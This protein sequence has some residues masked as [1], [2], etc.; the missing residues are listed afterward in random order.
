[1]A[2]L[3]LAIRARIADTQRQLNG[4]AVSADKVEKEFNQVAGAAKNV[5]REGAKA[6]A[7]LGR[8]NA[9]GRNT[10]QI[11]FQAGQAVSDFAV[12]GI[13][14]AA[15]NL[16]FL[17]LQLGA[18]SPV[19]LGVTALSVAFL[20]FEDDITGFLSGTSAEIENLRGNVKSLADELIQVRDGA[21]V[22]FEGTVDE[23]EADAER[24][25]AV[26]ERLIAQRNAIQGR[27][28][29]QQFQN[30]GGVSVVA[31]LTQESKELEEQVEQINRV[32]AR[33]QA[34][35]ESINTT[36]ED[37]KLLQT[38]IA[39][40]EG[41]TLEKKEK[42][43]KAERE[44]LTLL[45]RAE[46]SNARLAEE[47]Q[48]LE[49]ID[50]SRLG[51][52]L[53]QNAEYQ[54]Q[55]RL[56]KEA[57]LARARID[58]VARP[59]RPGVEVA[60]QED[61]FLGVD[62]DEIPDI[63]AENAATI[64]VLVDQLFQ[65]GPALQLNM[66]DPMAEAKQRAQEV[67]NVL[68]SGLSNAIGGLASAIATGEDPFNALRG[69]VGD[70]AQDL[71]KTFIGFGVAGLALDKFL[72][73]PATALIAGAGLVGL[74]AAL[75]KS[76]QT[77]TDNFTSGGSGTA[78]SGV[79]LPDPRQARDGR[80]R[81]GVETSEPGFSFL[82]PPNLGFGGSYTFRIQGADLVAVEDVARRQQARTIGRG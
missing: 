26:I 12:A 27:I 82:P 77:Q 3:E 75:K 9:G 14:G 43:V 33:Q 31:P 70:F 23:L 7:A 16:E 66:I 41:G 20:A 56:L 50:T 76:A 45:E 21:S 44:K 74:G 73:N 71:G 34:I 1:M 24:I 30:I 51:Q 38:V 11:F 78:A 58:G 54:K 59:D 55:I 63:T 72:T 13:R 25:A 39:D 42:Q 61:I 46:Q 18:S 49:N 60:Q 40:L 48:A 67:T 69:Q 80:F 36:V 81:R 19:I 29:R 53:L 15:N 65:L 4:V 64:G 32:I 5:A 8:V 79:T 10:Q 57:A 47:L 6:T 17:A 35:Q 62:L 68:Q 28:G 37:Q 22:T 2:D 52:I